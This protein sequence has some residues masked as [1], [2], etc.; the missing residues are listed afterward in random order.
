MKEV[1][2]ATRPGGTLDSWRRAALP[3]VA[4]VGGMVVPAAIFIAI[5]HATGHDGLL[6]GWA[7]PCVTDIAFSAM[8]ARAIFARHP[9]VPF[10]MLLAIADDVPR[11]GDPGGCFLSA[12]RAPPGDCR[13]PDGRRSHRRSGA[14]ATA[15]ADFLAVSC[16]RRCSVLVGAVPGRTA[17]SSR[18]RADRPVSATSG[19]ASWTGRRRGRSWG[20][21][22]TVRPRSPGARA[23]RSGALRFC[24]TRAC[25]IGSAES[26]T[27]AV[28]IAILLGKPLGIGISV[29]LAVSVGLHMPR[30]LRWQD[31]VVVGCTAG[32]G[33]TVA[34]FFA[35]AAFPPG[36]LL[37]AA[38]TGALLSIVS[39]VI[40]LAAA[41]A[42]RVGRFSA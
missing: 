21:A 1:V 28:L 37:E 39:G 15:H 41:R 25:K 33:F 31:V 36:P 8:V 14:A 24:E 34:L 40:A 20:R 26:G 38:E 6:R 5:V 16:C 4:A 30:H 17:S 23:D 27:W 2:E 3:L 9:A 19:K 18:A 35:T 13:D 29:A 32:I 12:P 42:L 11:P 22:G 10:L 7:I